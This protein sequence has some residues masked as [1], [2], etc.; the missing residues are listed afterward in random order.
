MLGDS[1]KDWLAVLEDPYLPPAERLRAEGVVWALAKW[2]SGDL[3]VPESWRRD[4]CGDPVRKPTRNRRGSAT[5]LKGELAVVKENLRRRD[6]AVED[7]LE[8]CE[9][10]RAENR[11]LQAEVDLL[12]ADLAT[13]PPAPEGLRQSPERTLHTRRFAR[14]EFD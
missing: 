7:A 9:S 10:L 2:G 4:L 11:R 12:K 14:L 1:I 6:S 3:E 5:A 8:T 13:R